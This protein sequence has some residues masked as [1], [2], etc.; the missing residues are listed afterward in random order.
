M[1]YPFFQA[2]LFLL[3]F[4]AWAYS[5]GDSAPTFDAFPVAPLYQGKTAPVDL[6]HEEAR[7]FQTHLRR[8]TKE[9]VNFAGQYVLTTWGAGSGCTYGAIVS[10]ATGKVHL[11]PG[12][13]CNLGRSSDRITYQKDSRLLILTGYLNDQDPNGRYFYELTPAGFNH[14]L[15]LPNKPTWETP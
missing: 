13:I 2:V 3:L 4:P 14:L 6:S 15:T 8:T 9:P 7:E 10:K 11:L 5:G 12:V 1:K